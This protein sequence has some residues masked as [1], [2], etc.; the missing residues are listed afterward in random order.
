MAAVGRSLKKP[1]ALSITEPVATADQPCV[2]FGMATPWSSKC[3]QS[4][5]RTW[6]HSVPSLSDL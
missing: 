3:S 1:L 4:L 2:N 6:Y 5:V